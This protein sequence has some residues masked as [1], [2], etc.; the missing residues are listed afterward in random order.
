MVMSFKFAIRAN[1][2]YICHFVLLRL[3]ITKSNITYEQKQFN[4]LGGL[5]VR[6]TFRNRA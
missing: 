6:G 5:V 2:D 3:K 1:N 4:E